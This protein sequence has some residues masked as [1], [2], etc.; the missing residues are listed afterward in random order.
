MLGGV[1]MRVRV[2]VIAWGASLEGV[3]NGVLEMDV[4]GGGGE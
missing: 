2:C 4:G 1:G 3:L